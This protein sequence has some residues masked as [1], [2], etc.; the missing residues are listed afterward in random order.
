MI[1]GVKKASLSHPF[2]KCYYSVSEYI[3]EDGND[4][5]G[6]DSGMLPIPSKHRNTDV[7]ITKTDEE[8]R[9]TSVKAMFQM[10]IDMICAYLERGYDVNKQDKRGKTLLMLYCKKR[11]Y[12]HL[13]TF[14][15]YKPNVTLSDCHGM[16]CINHILSTWENG[17]D[18]FRMIRILLSL[19]DGTLLKNKY[20]GNTGFMTLVD[21]VMRKI[22]M[23]GDNWWL[24]ST[25]IDYYNDILKLFIRH[26]YL[27]FTKTTL[28]MLMWQN[29]SFEVSNKRRRF[30]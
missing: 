2:S 1:S 24:D 5:Y 6:F 3:D 10:N 15:Y 28:F 23:I 22:E 12:Y 7:V 20:N 11:M 18:T 16:S 13:C 21:F 27:N 26:L 29:S 19:D 14:V 17:D 4:E 8:I 25:E 30:Q 9:N